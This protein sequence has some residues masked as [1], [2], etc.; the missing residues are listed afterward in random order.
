MSQTL[1]NTENCIDLD[2]TY[3][4]TANAASLPRFKVGQKG[5]DNK[6]AGTPQQL[7]TKY[8]GPLMILD[9]KEH[10]CST[11]NNTFLQSIMSFN[12]LNRNIPFP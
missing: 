7:K 4:N 8:C 3:R 11:C 2:K 9:A 10:A 6:K 1:E 5:N 12:F